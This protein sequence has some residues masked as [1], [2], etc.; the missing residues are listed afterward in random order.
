[1][2]YSE[3][4]RRKKYQ[5]RSTALFHGPNWLSEETFHCNPISG[6]REALGTVYMLCRHVSSLCRSQAPRYL[7]VPQTMVQPKGWA[8]GDSFRVD[9]PRKCLGD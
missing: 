5:I 2:N 7:F 4:F 8:G 9:N 1:M 6:K 3:Y